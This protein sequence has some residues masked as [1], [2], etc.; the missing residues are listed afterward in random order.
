MAYD[1]AI[2]GGMMVDGTGAVPMR[3]GA[4]LRPG[5]SAR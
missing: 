4:A 5:R 3:A 2:R 1:I